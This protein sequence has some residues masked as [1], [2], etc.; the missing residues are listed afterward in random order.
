ME[1]DKDIEQLKAE[2]KLLK[3]TIKNKQLGTLA[4]ENERLKQSER[5]LSRIC[6][7]LKKD[8]ETEK[9]YTLKY[10][11]TLQEIKEIAERQMRSCSCMLDDYKS[12]C[13]ECESKYAREIAI[14]ILQKISDC[15]VE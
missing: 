15:E 2:N 10:H 4:E 13:K 9:S 14:E 12:G 7:G 3:D 5:D 6:Q 11:T 8:I 1:M